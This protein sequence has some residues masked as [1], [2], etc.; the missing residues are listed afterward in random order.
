MSDPAG[1]DAPF[2][3]LRRSREWW[4]IGL[5]ITALAALL[6]WDG[7][8]RRADAAFYDL[9]RHVD[10]R[11]PDPTLLIV[12]IDDESLRDEGPWPWPRA[13]HAALLDRLRAAGARLVGYD[14]LFLESQPGDDALAAAMRRGMPVYLPL[15]VE[16]PGMN[17]ADHALR[18]PVLDLAAAAAGT[19][20]VGVSGDP[21]GPVRHGWLWDG[22]RAQG[23]PHL[24]LRIAAQ[25]GVTPPDRADA[26][27]LIPYAGPSGHYPTIS[28]AA[29]LKGQ[30]PPELLRGRAILVGAT[31]P[32]LG[33][34]HP[35][36]VGPGGTMAGVEMQANL[37]DGLL[38]H[39]LIREGGGW[40]AF[41]LAAPALWLLLFA[42]AWAPPRRSLAILGLLLLLLLGGG[43]LSLL[44]LRLWAPPA[45]A[46]AMLLLLYPLWNWRRLAAAH[47]YMTAELERLGDEP[48]L[49]PARRS[50]AKLDPVSREAALL[51]DAIA[52]L[53]DLSAFIAAILDQL[54]DRVVVT[55]REGRIL[56]TNAD[57]PIGGV[58]PREGQ[59]LAGL[60]VGL[61]PAPGHDA[62]DMLLQP[63]STVLL[64]S[65]DRALSYSLASW[66]DGSGVVAGWLARFSDVTPLRA[67]EAQRE[68]MLRFLTHDMRSPQAS[69][70]A[71]L[72][73]A[74]AG[75]IEAGLSDR[76][77]AYARRTLDLA[78]GFVHLARA[79][80]GG[81]RL[82]AI[83]LL[84]VMID[85]ADDLWPQASAR[86]VVVQAE[87]EGGD[88]IG[89]G[90]RALLTRA[91]VNLLGN[92]IR[93]SPAG[94]AV[95]M[96][97]AVAPVEGRAMAL[98]TVEDDGPGVAPEVAPKLFRRFASAPDGVGVGLGLSFVDAV[99]RGHGGRAWC[100]SAAGKGARFCIA[101]ALA[102]EG[103]PAV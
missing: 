15:L 31:A 97:V 75:E 9:L 17:G 14:V 32:G 92:A 43:A 69:I 29:I 72:S 33:D 66:S 68:E 99:A 60:L 90:D 73:T 77:A 58:A 88:V 102:E 93:H 13:R 50:L 36:A 24:A 101:I 42:L 41:A 80:A 4:L 83:G 100:E 2:R 65:D 74:Q 16:R 8:L 18:Q 71:C 40:A 6:A 67:V 95:R 64:T 1:R 103:S 84:D 86:G 35:V 79:E 53:R 48:T 12:A 63:Q 3:P 87:A 21:D 26:P 20:H 22:G 39:R 46:V 38:H 61:R 62:P 51:Q 23:V 96:S 85:A 54:P 11:A 30:V 52:R 28:A 78:D 56:F 55:D 5:A 27:I 45:T 57:A 89:V 91:L 94:G 49:L 98:L 59:A 44:V 82:E 37:L 81:Y 47:R 34:Q 19:G 70:L 10:G 76:I 7:T 25:L